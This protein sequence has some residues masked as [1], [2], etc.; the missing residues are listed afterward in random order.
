MPSNLHTHTEMMIMDR[1][2][3]KRYNTISA[4]LNIIDPEGTYVPGSLEHN[5]A[6]ETILSWMAEMEPEDVLKKSR[7]ARCGF[8]YKRYI[9]Q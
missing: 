8:R 1:Q 3:N 6:T 5:W 4:A 7:T 2:T 9:W